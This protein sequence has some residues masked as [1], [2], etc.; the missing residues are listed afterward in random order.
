MHLQGPYQVT[1]TEFVRPNGERREKIIDCNPAAGLLARH[2]IEVG[3]E[4]SYE[5]LGEGGDVHCTVEREEEFL[6]G[7][8]QTLSSFVA[9]GA[10]GMPEAIDGLLWDAVNAL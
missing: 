5:V 6:P 8:T 9:F 10:Y 4:L 7:E 3:C 2:L 1:F